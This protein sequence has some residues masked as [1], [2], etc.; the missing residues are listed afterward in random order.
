LKIEEFE[1]ILDLLSNG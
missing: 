1:E